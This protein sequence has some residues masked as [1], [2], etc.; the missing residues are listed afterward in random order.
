MIHYFYLT[1]INLIKF[2]YIFFVFSSLHY[3]K[4]L[5]QNKQQL[6]NLLKQCM[7]LVELNNCHANLFSSTFH[8]GIKLHDNQ[9]KTK[10]RNL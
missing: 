10:V 6:V 8:I 4:I 1:V 9:I 2:F 7:Q 3:H 5:N